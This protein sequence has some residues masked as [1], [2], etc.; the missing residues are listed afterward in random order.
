MKKI[1]TLL[2][3]LTSLM[4]INA[5]TKDSN[6]KKIHTN[7]QQ[8]LLKAKKGDA[9]A[10]YQ[11]AQSILRDKKP[12]E[13]YKWYRKAAE[14]GH[15]LSQYK[16]GY[17]LSSGW[18]IKQDKKEAF[19]WYIK[20][21]KQGYSPA[22]N[23]IGYMFYKGWATKIDK[24]EAF[25]W[26]KKSADQNDAVGQMRIGKLYLRGEG[27]K[28][29]TDEAIKWL[30]KSAD[31]ENVDAIKTIGY[32]YLRGKGVEKNICKG[33]RLLEKVAEQGSKL[34]RLIIND[35]Y[36]NGEG[37]DKNLN[38]AVEWFKK[39]ID[40]GDDNAKLDLATLYYNQNDKKNAIKWFKE[41]AVNTKTTKTKQAEAEYRLGKIYLEGDGTE[42]NE[43]EAI[44]WL[45]LSSNH[46]HINAS[47]LLGDFYTS[48]N[49]ISNT[50]NIE[51]A[52][53]LYKKAA[54]N[55]H[56]AN[57]DNTIIVNLDNID[58]SD[59]RVTAISKWHNTALDYANL[60]NV[61][62]Q[63]YLGL[64]FLTKWGGTKNY[65]AAVRWL[66]IAELNGNKSPL[67]SKNM[68]EA[69]AKLS[70]KEIA[71][72]KKEAKEWLANFDKNNK[73]L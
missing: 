10:Q 47:I 68:L 70:P 62:A 34:D 6:V 37:I 18:G 61:E 3:V 45:E 42:K 64:S 14:Q 67:L 15:V 41:T 30:K 73:S 22:Q 40:S 17:L 36:L 21:A 71:E 13:A 63:L 58:Y 32:L 72:A 9:E 31:Q 5:C 2:L 33:M 53:K 38:E 8:L 50:K 69:E 24:K 28:K 26:Y 19:S 25:K 57:D 43:K 60:G 59:P 27:V 46:N 66:Y 11:Y 54:E 56:K 23:Q 49:N 16:M 12:T 55:N 44:H 7:S 1:L 4:R 52:L 29:N 65:A 20:A 35:L 51:K 48:H 39:T